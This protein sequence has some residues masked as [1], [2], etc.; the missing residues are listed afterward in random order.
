MNKIG[1]EDDYSNHD[2]ESCCPEIRE[3]IGDGIVE[4]V[5]DADCEVMEGTEIMEDYDF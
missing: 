3:V 1:D 4:E 2:T 5:V